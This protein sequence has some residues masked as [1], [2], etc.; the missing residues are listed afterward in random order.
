LMV[1][2]AFYLSSTA[3]IADYRPWSIKR[4]SLMYSERTGERPK[5]TKRIIESNG[6]NERSGRWAN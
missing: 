3:F 2:F 1:F 5:R 6:K 4:R